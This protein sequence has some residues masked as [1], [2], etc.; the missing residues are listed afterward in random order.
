[1]NSDTV[2]LNARLNRENISIGVTAILEFLFT[3]LLHR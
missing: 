3:Q 2:S 1:M